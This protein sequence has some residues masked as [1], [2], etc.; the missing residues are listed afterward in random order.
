V[1]EAEGELSV[2]PGPADVASGLQAAGLPIDPTEP[3]LVMISGGPDS[4]FLLWSLVRLG[5]KVVAFHLDHALR[6]RSRADAES[7]RQ[8]ASDLGVHIEVVRRRP[9]VPSGRSFETA[10]RAIRYEEAR[11]A[12][13]RTGCKWI[14][15]GHTAD[16]QIETF[17]INLRRGAG[18][19]GLKGIPRRQEPVARPMLALWKDDVRRACDGLGIPYVDDP[20][21]L[22]LSILRNRIRLQ[23][24]PALQSALG[25]QFKYSLLRQTDL[26]REDAEYL[27]SCALS[28]MEAHMARIPNR[29]VL[30]ADADWFLQLPLPIARRVVRLGFQRLTGKTAPSSRLVAAALEAATRGGS[31]DLGSGI[32]FC[33]EG[34]RVVIRPA[35][36]ESPQPTSGEIPG[37]IV[38]EPFGIRLTA[39]RRPVKD[40]DLAAGFRMLP[41]N[42]AAVRVTIGG[43]VVVRAPLAG[44]RFSPYGMQGSKPLADFLSGEGLCMSERTL[45]PILAKPDGTIVWVIGHRISNEAAV[46]PGATEAIHLV[47]EPICAAEEIPLGGSSPKGVGGAK[48]ATAEPEG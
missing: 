45:T 10:A 43:P 21:N 35:V 26:L 46:H 30:L 22:D 33:R 11:K 32:A 37:V 6:D 23:A 13:R 31:A 1:S 42:E 20:T 2:H 28:E 17:F 25:E 3:Y 18:L 19:D 36:L 41:P 29:P 8:L 4:S 15:T 16:D 39:T 44:E 34:K 40:S 7:A 12:A 14:L 48:E 5:T 24:I 38:A 27:N 47:A 9:E